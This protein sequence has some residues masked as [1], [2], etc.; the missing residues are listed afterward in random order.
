MSNWQVS[1]AAEAIHRNA[2]VWDNHVCLPHVHDEKWMLELLR[3]RNSGA[4]MVVVNL[5][6]AEIPFEEQVSMANYYRGWLLR[7]PTDFL[8]V[9]TAA[10][11][12]RA[13]SE[14]KLGVAFNVEG[15]FSVEGRIE[16]IQLY[17]ELGVRW[18]LMA[19]NRNN[20][21]A[22][23]C[24]DDDTGL[25]D[26][27]YKVIAEMDRVGLVKCC[28]HTGY[29]SAL[30][31]L[32][33]TD[34]PT[35]FS[36]SNPLALRDH[37]RNIPDQL[38]S[39]CAATGG[40]VCINGVGIFLGDNDIR[41]QTFADHVDH[42]VDLVGIDH[43]GMGLDYVY[44]MSNMLAEL[45]ASAHI[46]PPE[47]GYS[48]ELHFMAPEAMPEITEALLQRNYS[49]SDIGKLLGGNLLRVADQ[50]WK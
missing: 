16:R 40:V 8:L 26:Y 10:D 1:S 31:V 6:D 13:K 25:T 23:G 9:E 44:D 38:I 49:E 39:A 37:P 32:T 2:L 14:S 21:V 36:H 50:V 20:L 48:G 22:G 19:Y 41:P 35:I 43:V 34:T 7:N 33:H 18:M 47:L 12:R 46:W 15:A 17:Y 30:D 29:R 24:H 27:G 42:V 3:H 5:G 28:T 45:A 4:S 11:V